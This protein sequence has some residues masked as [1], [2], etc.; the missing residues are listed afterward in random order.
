MSLPARKG[1]RAA[2]PP[3]RGV[4]ARRHLG[5]RQAAGGGGTVS[6]SAPLVPWICCTFLTSSG[7]PWAIGPSG[8]LRPRVRQRRPAVGDADE[9]RD[10]PKHLVHTGDLLDQQEL[11]LSRDAELRHHLVPGLIQLPE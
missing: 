9:P 7:V 3:R 4:A 10:A 1:G 6:S 2:R 8:L 5:K 11:V